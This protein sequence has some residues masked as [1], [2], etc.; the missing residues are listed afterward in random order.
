[1]SELLAHKFYSQLNHR[2]QCA[3]KSYN[4]RKWGVEKQLIEGEFQSFVQFL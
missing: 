3:G 1:M 4:G 2:K